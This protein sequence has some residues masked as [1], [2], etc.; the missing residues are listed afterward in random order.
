MSARLGRASQHPGRSSA[1][2]DGPGKPAP[3]PHEPAASD[4]ERRVKLISGILAPT[5]VLTALLFYYGYVATTAEYGYFGISM[6][7]LDLSTQ[8]FLLRSV[9]ALYVPL[10]LLLLLIVLAAWGHGNVRRRLAARLGDRRWRRGAIV[11]VAGG[12]VVF[13]RGFIGVAFP[14]VAR[15]EPI[16]VTPVCLGVGIGA[17]T[18]GRHVLVVLTRGGSSPRRHWTEP[19]GLV[20]VVGVVVLSTFWAANSFAAAYG[21]GR[22]E[23][24]ARRIG[25]RPAVVLDTTERLYADYDG[26]EERPLPPGTD[27]RFHYRYLGLRLLAESGGRM[28]LVPE[29]WNPDSG[30]VLVVPANS[31][32]RLQFYR[33]ES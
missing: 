7:S 33:S 23:Q 25:E 14:D 13:A 16:A 6:G 2:A 20:A 17:I 3:P 1:R 30:A 28:F 24:I 5:T 21:T 18:Y 32:V 12:A 26:L 11:A 27:Q 31:N 8:D 10:G 15:T 9:A 29:R 4:L 22:A 19:V